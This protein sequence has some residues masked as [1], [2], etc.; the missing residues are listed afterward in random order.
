M[1]TNP[2]L[3]YITLAS[4]VT[5]MRDFFNL[6]KLL[7]WLIVSVVYRYPWYSYYRKNT[8]KIPSVHKI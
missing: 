3:I 5:A 6:K 8:V 2:Y 4:S 1:K 7:R